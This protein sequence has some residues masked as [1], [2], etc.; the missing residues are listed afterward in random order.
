MWGEGRG[1]L[2]GLG[3]GEGRGYGRRHGPHGT[4]LVKSTDKPNAT[5]SILLTDQALCSIL[6]TDLALYRG[7][8][9]E[10]RGGL[11]GLGGG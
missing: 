11:G 3:G 2:G 4:R 9:G 6:L 10:G 7:V 5:F 1:G 8:W